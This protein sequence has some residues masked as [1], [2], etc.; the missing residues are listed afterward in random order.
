[1]T[2]TTT[3]MKAKEP[4]IINGLDLDALAEAVRGIEED[5]A[6]GIVG[7]HVRSTW[8][9]RTRS[10][11]EVS[12]YTLAGERIPRRFRIQAD[13]PIELLGDNTAPNPQELLMS[14]LNACMMVGYVA[15]AALRGITIES[16]EIET[17]GELDL[18]GFLGIDPKVKPGYD[19]LRAT[20]RIKGDGTPEQFREIHEAVKNL[21]PNYF[22]VTQP[23]RVDADLVVG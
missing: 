21:S 4:A 20:V 5:P 23:V 17:E 1:M 9:G 18:R 16:L 8:A 15:G 11:S 13:E 3:M 22:N 6:K 2:K 14:A 19:A 12:A 7:F 10:E